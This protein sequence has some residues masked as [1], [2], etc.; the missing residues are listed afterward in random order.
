MA[1]IAQPLDSVSQMCDSGATVIFDKRGGWV[2]NDTGNVLCTF[3]R[4]NDTYVR[5]AWVPKVDSTRNVGKSPDLPPP[6]VW[7]G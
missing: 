2:L 6:F 5:R 4:R 7:Q 1:D 3:E